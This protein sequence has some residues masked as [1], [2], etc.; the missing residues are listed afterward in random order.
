MESIR[1]TN[2]GMSPAE[3]FRHLLPLL[4]EINEWVGDLPEYLRFSDD[5]LSITQPL[6][7]L[8][9]S[10]QDRP[11]SPSS[12]DGMSVSSPTVH[13]G[14]GFSN[15]TSP[16]VLAMQCD[17]LISANYI[18]LRAL[19]P[20]IRETSDSDMRQAEQVDLLQLAIPATKIIKY[21]SHLHS[22]FKHIRPSMFMCYSFTRNLFDSSVTLAHITL[23]QPFLEGSTMSYLESAVEVLNDPSVLTG[24]PSATNSE[25]YPSEAVK[26]VEALIQKIRGTRLISPLGPVAAKRK[27]EEIDAALVHLNNFRLPYVGAGVICTTPNTSGGTFVAP[28]GP[29]DAISNGSGVSRKESARSGRTRK[30]PAIK[31][32][33][34]LPTEKGPPAVKHKSTNGQVSVRRRVAKK[35]DSGRARTASISTSGV[36]REKVPPVLSPP[37][38]IPQIPQ[39]APQILPTHSHHPQPAHPQPAHPHHPPHQQ[40]VPPVYFQHQQAP[41]AANPPTDNFTLSSH[42]SS[43]PDLVPTANYSNENIYPT[44]M[45]YSHAQNYAEQHRVSLPVPTQPHHGQVSYEPFPGSAGVPSA[46]PSQ[47]RNHQPFTATAPPINYPVA[48]QHP[49]LELLNRTSFLYPRRLSSNTHLV[50]ADATSP[51]GHYQSRGSI[52]HGQPTAQDIPMQAPQHQHQ[53]HYRQVQAMTPREGSQAWTDNATYPTWNYQPS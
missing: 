25:N 21:W 19:L 16:F 33:P 2:P 43:P 14:A 41:S 48:A 20:L 1:Q 53:H 18:K 45:P 51:D 17:L 47:V 52:D 7:S 39:P 46:S 28:Q 29:S 30:S 49:G 38:V 3:E 13:E 34:S 35:V 44:S 11:V 22:I 6:S 42:T 9:M 10:D 8:R 15:R 50:I 23:R 24:R 31:D 40:D 26:I 4:G 12:P 27:H 37:S 36:E 32:T 5:S